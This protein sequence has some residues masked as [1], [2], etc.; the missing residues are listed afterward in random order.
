M[1]IRIVKTD[2]K[3][4]FKHLLVAALF[5]TAIVLGGLTGAYVAVKKTLPDV[6]ELETFEPSLL[7][8]I[9]ADDG[10]SRQGDRPGEA[11]RHRL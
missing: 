6:S 9:Y 7:T 5:A 10:K 1:I 2:K 11:D 3:K 8:S 4:L